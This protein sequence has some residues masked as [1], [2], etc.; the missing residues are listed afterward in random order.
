MAEKSTMHMH[1][2]CDT[3]DLTFLTGGGGPLAISA[4]CAHL[5]NQPEKLHH[6]IHKLVFVYGCGRQPSKVTNL[7]LFLCRLESLYRSSE[8]LTNPNGKLPDE[9]LYGR[10]GCLYSLLFMKK[11]CKEKVSEDLIVS[12]AKAIIESGRQ[13]SRKLRQEGHS[14]TPPLMFE[15]H[16][17]KYLG[18]AH[19]IA[20]IIYLLLQVST[21]LNLFLVVYRIP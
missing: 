7:L 14:N 18:P 2:H 9:L 1:L 11:F 10:A 16:E 4:V 5:L 3:R 13:L 21:V 8:A 12:I 6:F 15:W 19:G 20:G 17:K